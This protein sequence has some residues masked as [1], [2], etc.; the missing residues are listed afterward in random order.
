M[1]LLTIVLI[2]LSYIPCEFGVKGCVYDDNNN[3]FMELPRVY[4]REVF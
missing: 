1:C 4:L 2:I 3:P